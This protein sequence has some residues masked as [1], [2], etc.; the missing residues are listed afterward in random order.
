MQEYC[1]GAK[2]SLHLFLRVK[3]LSDPEF[4][5]KKYI[6]VFNCAE[7]VNSEL[8]SALQ[9]RIPLNGLIRDRGGVVEIACFHAS[10][11]Y[12]AL[13]DIITVEGSSLSDRAVDLYYLIDKISSGVAVIN[14]TVNAILEVKNGNSATGILYSD[15][16]EG[17]IT[18]N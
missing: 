5:T 12:V 3:S 7:H 14:Q 11:K 10:N 6:H 15:I 16:L 1:K 17:R 8:Y 4:H 9:Y 18:S 2:S 13:L